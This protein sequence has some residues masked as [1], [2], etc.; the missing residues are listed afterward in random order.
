V[1]TVALGPG[2]RP[3]VPQEE[4]LKAYEELCTS[5][6]AIDDFRAKLLGFLPLATG[7]GIF[8]LFNNLPTKVKA[9]SLPLGISGFAITLGLLSYEI[10]GIKKC[11]ALIEAGKHL[12]DSLHIDGQFRERPQNVARVINEP[13]AAGIVYPTVLAAWTYLALHYVSKEQIPAW[14]PAWI[15]AIVVFFGGF[16]GILIYD[17][18]LRKAPANNLE[19]FPRNRFGKNCFKMKPGEDFFYVFL[20][21]DVISNKTVQI[22]KISMNYDYFS[23]KPLR[24][25]IH[26]DG[27]KITTDDDIILKPPMLVDSNRTRHISL[28]RKFK[29]TLPDN[30][31]KD[32]LELCESIKEHL[33]YRKILIA[34]DVNLLG[35]S[36]AI[37]EEKHFRLAPEGK[38]LAVN[39]NKGNNA[40]QHPK[41]PSKEVKLA[42]IDNVYNT[43][44]AFWGLR[45]RLALAVVV[46]SLTLLAITTGVV[47]TN[48]SFT[49][50]GVALEIR[51]PIFLAAG[52][53]VLA[54]LFVSWYA[55]LLRVHHLY[56][57]I[58]RLYKS[59]DYSDEAMD[60][61]L[62]S[63]FHS[64]TFYGALRAPA[65]SRGG[66][67]TGPLVNAYYGIVSRSVAYLLVGL[68]P[69]VTEAWIFLRVVQWQQYWI[70]VIPGI[71]LLVTIS[72][73]ISYYKK[74]PSDA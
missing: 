36:G 56:N 59:L 11:H 27:K 40:E 37:R 20:D 26:V 47:S 34:F 68:L 4:K 7:T 58:R 62:T 50:F 66:K 2:Q 28:Y 41:K 13:F 57:E 67:S 5:Y 55:V 29:A 19:I 25:K 52:A 63:P 21:F 46:L 6:R 23:H 70:A 32:D 10:Y 30:Y 38:L 61:P 73:I 22:T 12:E 51:L 31:N 74:R 65:S 54:A 14:I 1:A 60:D 35:Q 44:K 16:A 64:A 3:S 18:W 42:Y 72:G 15:A 69:I 48:E 9:F 39:N 45:G 8:L 71:C 33:D 49:F 43:L 24:Q 53:I 17:F